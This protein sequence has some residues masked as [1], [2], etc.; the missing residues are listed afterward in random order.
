MEGGLERERQTGEGR[1]EEII[2]CLSP[3]CETCRFTVSPAVAILNYQTLREAV[4]CTCTFTDFSLKLTFSA[5]FSQYRGVFSISRGFVNIAGFSQ[6]RGVFSI[7][8]G[9]L[10]FSPVLHE[11][12]KMGARS[13]RVPTRDQ[14]SLVY[15]ELI[16]NKCLSISYFVVLSKGPFTESWFVD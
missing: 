15:K 3:T 4:L 7:S 16:S 11:P 10:N 5:G 12:K 8:R 6:Y 14:N 9:F 1:Y 13:A 2:L